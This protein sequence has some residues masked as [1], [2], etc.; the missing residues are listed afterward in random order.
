M[1]KSKLDVFGLDAAIDSFGE[2]VGVFN[3]EE[4]AQWEHTPVNIVEFLESEQFMNVRYNPSTGIGVYPLVLDDLVNIFGTNAFDVAAIKRKSFFSEAVGTGKSSRQAWISLYQTYKCLCLRNPIQWFNANG[5]KLLPNSKISVVCLSRTEE[6]AKEVVFQKANM[7]CLQSSWFTENY[8]PDPKIMS[9]L[10]FDSMPRN[11][12][13]HK[14]GKVYKNISIVP[15]SSSEYSVLGLDVLMGSLDEITKFQAAGDRSLTNEDT[16]QAEVLINALSARITSR[17]GDLGHLCGVGNPEHLAD[18]LERYS[19]LYANDPNVYI[20]KRRPV[21]AV[22]VPDFDPDL[23]D[24]RGEHV[25]PHFYFDIAKQKIISTEVYN[26]KK[27][28][29]KNIN[30]AIMR[31]PYGPTKK[32]Q[33]YYEGFRDRPEIALRDH[34]GQPTQSVGRWWIDSLTVVPQKVNKKRVSPIPESNLTPRPYY[35]PLTPDVPDFSKIIDIVREDWALYGIHID[36]AEVGDSATLVMSHPTGRTS[37]DA[38]KIKL[39]LVYRY[40]PSQLDPFQVSYIRDLVWWLWKVKKFPLGKV[41]ADQYQSLELLQTFT[42]WELNTEK[43]S[44]DTKGLE[45]FDNL[46]WCITE[47]RLDYFPFT[48]FESEIQS[49]ERQGKKVVKNQHSKD[50]VAQGYAGS[51]WNSTQLAL[52]EMFE[53]DDSWELDNEMVP[54]EDDCSS[55]AEIF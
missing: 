17:F 8:L 34:G 30:D 54:G 18:T 51:I 46:K 22:K 19:Q 47:D 38:A 50:D 5:A 23:L 24:E 4:E 9:K 42:A 31:I 49:L 44:V 21:W 37:K 32:S 13:L 43:L 7:A 27:K 15:G 3:S 25:F 40:Q 53:I 1:S 2:S 36:L 35:N 11:R 45:L 12:N 14:P 16:D 39:D 29:D 20:V 28:R 52:L 26:R 41:T 10:V 6:N 33:L 55:S 48:Q